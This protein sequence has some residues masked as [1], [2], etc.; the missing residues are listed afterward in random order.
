M[1]ADGSSRATEISAL[2]YSG[3]TSRARP[4]AGGSHQ[5]GHRSSPA[6]RADWAEEHP[7]TL[8]DPDPG[9]AGYG[10][11]ALDMTSL[12]RDSGPPSRRAGD[13]VRCTPSPAL[14]A[15]ASS[16]R[17]FRVSLRWAPLRLGGGIRQP[18]SCIAMISRVALG[19]GAFGLSVQR[20]RCKRGAVHPCCPPSRVSGQQR[21]LNRSRRS[22][23]FSFGRRKWSTARCSRVA[24]TAPPVSLQ[25]E[26][27]ALRAGVI[28][29]SGKLCHRANKPSIVRAGGK[30]SQ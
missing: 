6:R 13:R 8:R 3:G 12:A 21:R 17:A 2:S 4:D 18:A 1:M 30:K 10:P 7:D 29:A 11:S 28:L 24:A 15:G 16:G 5:P 22:R 14:G 19:L 26:L 9:F 20:A 23:N 27:F 25:M